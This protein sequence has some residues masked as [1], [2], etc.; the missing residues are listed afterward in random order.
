M[1]ADNILG[2]LLGIAGGTI[3]VASENRQV[4]AGPASGPQVMDFTPAM[5]STEAQMR[6]LLG[7]LW[8]LVQRFAGGN[9]GTAPQVSPWVQSGS[10]AQAG[11]SGTGPG[12]VPPHP[13]PLPVVT[14]GSPTTTGSVVSPAA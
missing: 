8:D 2:K 7:E 6:D 12:L 3:L 10:G 11:V 13:N 1:N 14:V 4:A 9:M 5:S